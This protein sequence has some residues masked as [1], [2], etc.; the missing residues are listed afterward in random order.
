MIALRRRKTRRMRVP[1][2]LTAMT[3]AT[4]LLA[5]CALAT[6]TDADAP[7]SPTPT[8]ACPQV[9]GVDLPPECAPYDPEQSMAQN[10]RY[11]DRMDM[12][13]GSQAAAD[14]AAALL[15][16]S[17]ESIRTSTAISVDAVEEAARG[18]GLSDITARGDAR[19]VEFGA[20]APEGGCVF[21]QISADAVAV[22]VG[23]YI[24]DGGCLP[25]Q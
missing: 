20:A 6:P 13:E 16:T 23:G 14:E 5:G 17:L 7:P 25:M 12:P 18:A 1:V 10:D 21:G 2:G 8:A 19:S 3:A 22:E 11:R 15:R 4:L 9:E 24:M